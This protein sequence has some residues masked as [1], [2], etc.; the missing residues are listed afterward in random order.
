MTKAIRSRFLGLCEGSLIH[1]ILHC[2]MIVTRQNDRQ[3]DAAWLA[4]HVCKKSKVLK[5]K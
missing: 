2:H 4:I 3:I 5:R 1:L